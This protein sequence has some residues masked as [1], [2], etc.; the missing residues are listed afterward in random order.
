V[1]DEVV[2]V[3]RR[4]GEDGVSKPFGAGGVDQLVLQHDRVLV[5]WGQLPLDEGEVEKNAVEAS[6]EGVVG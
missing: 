2:G 6:D 3:V 5:G 4:E 1:G